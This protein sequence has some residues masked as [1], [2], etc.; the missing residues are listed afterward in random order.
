MQFCVWT[1]P[2]AEKFQCFFSR[3]VQR[4][5]FLKNRKL[6]TDFV[7]FTVFFSF[8]FHLTCAG[9]ITRN[10]LYLL[11]QNN[12]IK[13]YGTQPTEGPQYQS[14]WPSV[15]GLNSIEVIWLWKTKGLYKSLIKQVRK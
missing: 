3:I 13:H 4:M 8:N 11:Q 10:R 2:T 7:Y 5:K 15:F 14:C 6:E 1:P 9:A 12:C